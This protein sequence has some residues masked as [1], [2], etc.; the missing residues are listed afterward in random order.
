MSH[1]AL[2]TSFLTV[3]YEYI[4][5][6]K[7]G[8][9]YVN[10]TYKGFFPVIDISADYRKS[11]GTLIINN[12]I[13]K[14]FTFDEYNVKIGVRIP[15]SFSTSKYYTRL[16]PSVSTTLIGIKHDASTPDNF[17]N[18]TINTLDYR[19]YSSHFLRMSARDLYPKW[20][21]SLEFNFRHSPFGIRDYG[22]IASAETYLFFP[23]VIK[24]H[25]FKVYA[26][27][28]KRNTVVSKYYF[29]DIINYPF[30]SFAVHSDA[31]YSANLT[32]FYPLLYPDLS[33]S[34]LLYLKRL[35]MNIFYGKAE[36]IYKSYRFFQQSYGTEINSELHFLRFVA[37]INIGYRFTYLPDDKSVLNEIIFGI[38]FSAIGG[39]QFHK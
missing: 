10:Y 9:Y 18:G 19:L 13:F 21:Q 3:G 12:S 26:G 5:A 32:Y 28:Q 37:P 22:N 36:S 35:D 29:S 31:L 24:H 7:T 23:S 27:F 25:G 33:I 34:S 20:G 4:N 38:N 16:Q 2:S 1:N 17:L 15:L 8:K 11:K 39:K 14:P 6:E 30:G